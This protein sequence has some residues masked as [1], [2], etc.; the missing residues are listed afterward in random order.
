MSLMERALV[1]NVSGGLCCDCPARKVFNL[2]IM[3]QSYV[4]QSGD[5]EMQGWPSQL[6]Y[7]GKASP[8]LS[9]FKTGLPLH[10]IFCI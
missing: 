10:E 6:H 2:K 7:P 3:M 5:R 9:S 1:A 8:I 4:Y